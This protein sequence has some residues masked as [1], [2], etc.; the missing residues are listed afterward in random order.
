MKFYAI[1]EERKVIEVNVKKGEISSQILPQATYCPFDGTITT[2]GKS[3][4]AHKP[5]SEPLEE[6]LPSLIK[7]E[8][9]FF[10]CCLGIEQRFDTGLGFEGSFLTADG[11]KKLHFRKHLIVG[12]KNYGKWVLQKNN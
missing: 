3:F 10:R 4:K 12:R 8:Y 5:V 9:G 7:T 6:N 11:I 1:T 2:E